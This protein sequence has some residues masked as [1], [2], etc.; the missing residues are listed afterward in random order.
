MKYGDI[1]KTWTPDTSLRDLFNILYHNG[2]NTRELTKK[3]LQ[4]I[5][6]AILNKYNP[7]ARNLVGSY[8]SYYTNLFFAND[9]VENIEIKELKKEPKPV[10]EEKIEEEV[11]VVVEKEEEVLDEEEQMKRHYL[12]TAKYVEDEQ[13]FKDLGIDN[14]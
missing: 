7:E 6:V 1:I 14:E 9:Y 11:A 12:K 4:N 5:F 8:I 13:L 2:F 3:E 10:V